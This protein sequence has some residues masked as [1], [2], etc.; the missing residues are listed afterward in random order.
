MARGTL[1]FSCYTYICIHYSCGFHIHTRHISIWPQ[2]YKK[3]KSCK[4]I[5]KTSSSAKSPLFFSFLLFLRAARVASS[6]TRSASW[7]WANPCVGATPHWR[8]ARRMRCPRPG[9]TRPS[10]T[11]RRRRI[12][13]HMVS[14]D[15]REKL[16]PMTDPCVYTICGNI[17]H[18]QKTQVCLH[19]VS[20]I[21]IRIRHGYGKLT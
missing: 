13:R 8:C 5:N 19:Y 18:Q 20:S 1:L 4:S 21:N 12:P 2:R 10:A 15:Q 17:Y 11:I 16:Y 14:C 9:N 6:T 7:T 3:V